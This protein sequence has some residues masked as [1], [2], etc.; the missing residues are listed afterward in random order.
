M[1]ILKTKT[2]DYV[3]EGR[4]KVMWLYDNETMNMFAARYPKYHG[5]AVSWEEYDVG[6]VIVRL[7]DGRICLYDDF[8]KR[9]YFIREFDNVNEIDEYE[10]KDRFSYLLKEALWRARK[11]QRELAEDIGV[12]EVSINNYCRGKAIPS[13]YILQRIADDL[14]CD[15]RD[16][17]PHDFVKK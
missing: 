9:L 3:M 15:V 17:L 8:E 1:E 7:D 6:Q 5:M 14:E 2:D 12:S 16:L 11:I 10:W 13:A 4:Q